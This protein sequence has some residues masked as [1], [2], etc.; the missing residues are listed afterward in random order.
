MEKRISVVSL[1]L[2]LC[3][4]F[5]RQPDGAWKCLYEMWNDNP[6]PGTPEKGPGD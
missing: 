2:M 3:F 6:L 1:V 4:A 5:A